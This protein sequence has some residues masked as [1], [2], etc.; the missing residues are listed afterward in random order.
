MAEGDLNAV[1]AIAEENGID[2]EDAQDYID[3]ACL[4]LVNPLMAAYGKIDVE[5]AELHMKG[6]MG[7]WVGYIK[8]RCGEDRKTAEAV[9]KKG[10]SLK[11]CVAALLC[12]S[13]K[14]Q[15]EI[16][17]GILR[18][19]GVSGRVTLGI[20]DMRKAKQLITEYYLKEDQG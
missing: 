14:N 12:W 8:A 13:F 7:D 1:Y 20:P 5:S 11:G 15:Q 19:A 17:P 18:A 4:Q 3:G 6:I 9:R 2:R 10:K 16:D